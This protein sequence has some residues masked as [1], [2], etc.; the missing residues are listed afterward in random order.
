MEWGLFTCGYQ[1]LPLEKAFA[2]AAAF[3]YDYIELWGGRPHAYAPD[4]LRGE[5]AGVRRLM[6]QYEMPVRVYT[7][8]H[9]AYPFNYMQGTELQ[10]QDS[11]DY[12]KLG[13]Q[14]AKE[15]GADSILMS[16]GHSGFVPKEES[17]ERLLKSLRYLIMEAERLEQK[18]VLETLTPFESDT[19][20]HLSELKEVLDEVNS[21]MLQGMCDVVPPYVQ[22]E[23]PADYVRV[24]GNRMAHLHLVDNDG[25]SDTHLIPGEGNMN[26]KTILSEMRGA[27]Y[28]GTATLELVTNYI[29]DPSGAAKLALERAK[30]LLV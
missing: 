26:L 5:I 16:V 29:D 3:G 30:E 6:D 10:W 7:P 4:L 2:D 21:P 23:D 9:N 27:G 25:V 12:L 15:L 24:L 11:M 28:D 1:R 18:I 22:G 8:E 13:L 17:R 19:C 20:T 14:C